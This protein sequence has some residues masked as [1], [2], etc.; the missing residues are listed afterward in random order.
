MLV[1]EQATQTSDITVLSARVRAFSA[2]AGSGLLLFSVL[3]VLDESYY[4]VS[5][6][7][8]ATLFVSAAYLL[9][10][11]TS[12]LGLASHALVFGV[13]LALGAT[14]IEDGVA[15]SV[16]LWA[17]AVVPI[18]AGYLLGAAASIGYSLIAVVPIWLACFGGEILG[19]SYPE[20]I[21]IG[22]VDWL[23]LRVL[24]LVSLTALATYIAVDYEQQALR[25]ARQRCAVDKAHS[26]AQAHHQEK[27][28]FLAVMSH[29]IRTP[30]NGVKG[31]TEHWLRQSLDGE[32]RE[33]VAVMNRCADNLLG[34]LQDIREFS[35]VDAGEVKIHRKPFCLARLVED[36]AR[37]FEAKASERG[38][39]LGIDAQQGPS[40]LLGDPQRITQV[41]SNLVGNAVKFTDQGEIVLRWRIKVGPSMK[42]QV[43][44]EV[45]D[46]GVGMSQEQLSRLFSEFSQVH[47]PGGQFRGGTGLGLTIS[48]GLVQAMGGELSVQSQPGQGSTFTVR[49]ELESSQERGTLGCSNP[50]SEE[51]SSGLSVLA[52]DDD[53]ISLLVQRLALEHMGCLVQ[54]C[55]SS[56]EGLHWALTKRF[57]LIVMDLRMPA[58]DGVET[59]REIRA[60][61]SLNTDTPA[62]ALTASTR[63]EDHERCLA[64]GMREVITKPFA[65]EQLARVVQRHAR[66]IDPR[67]GVA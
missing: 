63:A 47:D 67:R 27:N 64:V 10:L 51:F 22:L 61:S 4:T 24:A 52:V 59:L 38:V 17:L 29:E 14:H 23:G 7:G 11:K 16:S 34:M 3:R 65:F 37:L 36:V 41:L 30:M 18:T 54:D 8:V 35:S 32:T 12:W 1:S 39:S 5:L 13:A 25:V 40:W 44:L 49:L 42:S 53:P 43:L 48:Q 45:Q 50:L 46:Q 57:D 2:I 21:E 26:L 31:M 33:S 60:A 58:M 55:G 62:I 9:A 15:T 6:L 28:N 66:R 20:Q 56:Q 19:W